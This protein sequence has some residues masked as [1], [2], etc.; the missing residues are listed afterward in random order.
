MTKRRKSIAL[1]LGTASGLAGAAYYWLI[2]RPLPRAHGKLQLAGLEDQV[3]IIRDRWGVPHIY[4]NNTRDLMFAQ[5]FVHAQDRLWQMDLQRR[6]ASG[7]LSEVLGKPALDLDRWMRILGLQRVAEQEIGLITSTVRADLDAYAAGINARINQGRLPLEFTLLRYKPEAWTIADSLA[8]VKMMAW[9]LSVRWETKLLRAQLIARLGPDKAAEL[10][11]SLCN[12]RPLILSDDVD[13][14]A[15]GQSAL[16]RWQAARPLAGP[17]MEEGIGSNNWVLDGSRTASG[18]PLLANDM[19]LPM[20]IPA[21]WYENHLVANDWNV[22][23]ITFPGIPGVVSGHNGHVAWGF[24]NGF[25]DVQDLYIERLRHTDDGQVQYEYKGQWVDA[26]IVQ[27]EIR[28]KGGDTVVEK[29]IIT[30]HGPIINDFAPECGEQPIALRWTALEPGTMIYALYGMNRAR[31]CLEFRESLR[32]WM[33]PIQNTVYADAGGNIGY[34]FP[35]KVPIRAGGN[36][37]IPVPG[38]NGEHEWEGYIPFEELP[39][40]YNPPQGYIA[41]ANNR[42]A[43]ERYPYFISN[44]YCRGDRAQRITELIEARDKID[45]AYIR[46]MHMDQILPTAKVIARY[47]G[48]LETPHPELADVIKMMRDWDGELAANSSAAAVYEVFVRRMIYQTLSDK[49]G[50][51]TSRYAGK[52][53]TPM[54]NEVSMYGDHAL[55]WLQTTLAQ[56]HSHWFDLGHGET[57]DDVMLAALRQTVDFLTA[58]LGPNV[59]AWAW[60][61]LHTLTYTHT[62]GSVKPLDLLFNRGPY[63]VGGDHNTIWA[64]GAYYHDLSSTRVIGPPFRFIADLGDVRNCLG[65]LA[66]GQSGQPG[67]P[68]YDDQLKA[69]F[70]GDYHPM[71]YARKD[72]ERGAKAVLKLVPH[73]TPQ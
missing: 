51:L 57:R 27:E 16:K 45:I 2:R 46:R 4:A 48:Q 40:L 22:T 67:N 50:E 52:G 59:H 23:G 6:L 7:R 36:N 53:P 64:T 5:G 3:R 56:P 41:T 35:G 68:H 65:L 17:A 19:H 24:T 33:C 34:S 28:V 21:I 26:Q 72:V 37:Q 60:G 13:Y 54:L 20:N 49:L 71:L 14:A 12:D 55:A 62:L 44:D 15:L 1:I 11:P 73:S 69:W 66:P 8:W 70:V 38:W 32:N 42:V 58:K 47:I 29:V 43:D 10:E 39:H 31:N 63:P 18:L 30:H 61:K 9:G 25:A